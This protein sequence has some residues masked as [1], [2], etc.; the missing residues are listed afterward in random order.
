VRAPACF[1]AACHVGDEAAARR[2]V[3]A[4][5]A[6]QRDRLVTN[7]K[8]FGVDIRRAD[9]EADPMACQR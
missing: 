5:P 8:Q 2:L 1:L 4:V 3:T 9:C 7:C 6:P